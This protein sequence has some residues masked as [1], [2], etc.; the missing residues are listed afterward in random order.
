MPPMK[1]TNHGEFNM[2]MN[3]I[4][5]AFT[6]LMVVT[7]INFVVV[8]AATIG[9]LYTIDALKSKKEKKEKE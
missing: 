9:I 4:F 1:T 2:T 5:E 7:V 3:D 8:T 6:S